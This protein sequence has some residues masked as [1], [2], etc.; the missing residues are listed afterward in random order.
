MQF[1]RVSSMVYSFSSRQMILLWMEFRNELFVHISGVPQLSH[2]FSHL[3]YQPEYRWNSSEIEKIM[4][5]KKKRPD[6]RNLDPAVEGNTTIFLNFR[7]NS[8]VN[9]HTYWCMVHLREVSL[10]AEAYQFS[11]EFCTIFLI[12]F[13]CEAYFAVIS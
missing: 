10:G 2:L 9:A 13:L 7:P 12:S 3:F 8:D 1:Y 5:L 11:I 6:F 4:N